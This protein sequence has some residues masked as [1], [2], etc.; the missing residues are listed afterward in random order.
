MRSE[1]VHFLQGDV[2]NKGHAWR[3]AHAIRKRT[4]TPGHV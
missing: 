3:G 4:G 1:E 2:R